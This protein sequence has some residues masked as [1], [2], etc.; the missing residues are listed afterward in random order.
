MGRN[1]LFMVFT[2][3]KIEMNYKLDF[4]Q[5]NNYLNPQKK[6]SFIK[7]T[8]FFTSK[9]IRTNQIRTTQIR[10][11]QIRTTQIRTTQI[12]TTQIRTTQIR[13]PMKKLK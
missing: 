10:T 8:L 7:P 11:N 12:R 1:H 5:H 3:E 6:V 4:N 13:S 2:N 9:G